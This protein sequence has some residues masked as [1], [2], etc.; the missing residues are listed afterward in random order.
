MLSE[1]DGTISLD[2]PQKMFRQLQAQS[3]LI[4]EAQKWLAWHLLSEC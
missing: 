2:L 1:S 4:G 3:R